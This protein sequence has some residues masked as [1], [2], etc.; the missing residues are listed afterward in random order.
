MP[1][2]HELPTL[3]QIH[4]ANGDVHSYV[5]TGIAAENSPLGPKPVQAMMGACGHVRAV[6]IPRPI[7]QAEELNT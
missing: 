7:D 1:H 5:P 4:S 3:A 6:Y 2:T